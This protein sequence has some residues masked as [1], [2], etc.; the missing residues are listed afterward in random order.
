M[1]DVDV[2]RLRVFRA[3]VAS[4]TVQAAAGHLGYSPSAVSQQLAALQRETGLT[5]FEKAGRGI[6]PTPAGRLL[7]ARSDEVM[8]SLGRFAG[9]VADLRDGRSGT[10]S[11]GSFAS[12]GEAWIPHVAKVLAVELPDVI[13]SLD[14][15]YHPG[16]NRLTY[17]IEI[18]AEHPHGAPQTPTGMRRHVLLDEPFVLLVPDQHRLAGARTVALGDL[19]DERWI[20]DDPHDT[21]GQLVRSWWN[22]AGLNPRFVARTGDHHASIAFVAAGVGITMVPRLAVGV[23]PPTVR[24]VRVVDPEP[25]RRIVAFVREDADA[26]PVVSRAMEVLRETACAIAPR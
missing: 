22:A 19:G 20:D 24:E 15:D 1:H 10:L 13:L 4:G 25:M 2:N 26:K 9:L 8:D 7:A 17:D 3:V 23:L 18:S 21:C 6:V 5:L 11:I 12:A 16:D 14:I